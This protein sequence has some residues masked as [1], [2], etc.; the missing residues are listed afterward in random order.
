[1]GAYQGS[2][3]W[4]L[5]RQLHVLERLALLTVQRIVSKLPGLSQRL[6]R[7]CEQVTSLAAITAVAD[8]MAAESV[9]GAEMVAK[10]VAKVTKAA[11]DLGGG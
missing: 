6:C 7:Q 8:A 9:W 1:M 11:Y 4:P 5:A 10:M 2:L 3:S